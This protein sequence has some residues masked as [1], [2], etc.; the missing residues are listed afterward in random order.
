M[1]SKRTDEA[2]VL[3]VSDYSESSQIV[4]LLTAGSGLVRLIAKGARRGT[5]TRFSAGIDLLEHGTV[6]F[7][8]AHGDAG[9]GN[10]AEWTQRDAFAAVRSDL[11]SLYAALYAVELVPPLTEEYDPHPG[12]FESLL[13]LLRGLADPPR[14]LGAAAADRRAAVVAAVLRFQVRL[15]NEIGLMPRLTECVECRRPAGGGAGAY[16][17]ASA[18]GLLCRDCEMH[19]ADKRR[20]PPGVLSRGGGLC[21]TV[22][23]VELLNGYLMHVANRRFESYGPLQELLR[24]R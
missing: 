23:A 13:T 9:L 3:R 10:L 19:H 14:P 12:L 22:G 15:L 20:V 7:V 5:K 1:L 4:S 17:S 11:G 6:T 16:F 2:V 18:G 8:P 24:N 21:V